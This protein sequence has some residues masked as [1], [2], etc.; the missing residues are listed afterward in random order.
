[1]NCKYCD[2]KCKNVNSLVQHEIRCKK[3]PNKITIKRVWSDEDRKKHSEIMKKKHN[4]KNRVWSKETLEKLS[5]AT[6]IR[7]K[8]LWTEEKKKKHSEIMR[9]IVSKNPESYSANNVCGRTK[10]TEYNG[11]TLNGSWE[12][13]VAKWFDR[14]NIKWTNKIKGFK[15]IWDNKERLYF[16]DFY[17]I[18]LDLYVEVKGYERERDR[19]KWAVVDNLIVIKK[20]DINKIKND[21]F[22]IKK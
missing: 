4:N 20:N 5:K 13:L 15:Y 16:P 21:K 17:L 1:M 3:N 8:S 10:L 7:N 12:L 18:E 9:K 6:K 22:I 19:A 2:R 11:H 14:N